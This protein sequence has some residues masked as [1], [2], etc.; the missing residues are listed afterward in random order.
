[1]TLRFTISLHEVGSAFQRAG[2]HL[3]WF[4]ETE[5]AANVV[6]RLTTLSTSIDPEF[7]VCEDSTILVP[8]VRL[9]DHRGIYL[10]HD[11][12]VSANRGHVSRLVTGR[13]EWIAFESQPLMVR[14]N[15]FHP[16]PLGRVG[17][18]TGL[19]RYLADGLSGSEVTFVSQS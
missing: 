19:L 3:D 6:S 8:C 11:G 4:F 18:P 14:F 9:P 5:N 10:D 13:F 12:E 17:L 1:M 7:E 15:K 16:V 2:D